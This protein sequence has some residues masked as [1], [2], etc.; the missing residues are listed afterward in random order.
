M[1]EARLDFFRGL[2]MFIIF[3]AHLPL[4]PWNDWIPARFGP[5]DATEMFVFCSGFASAIAFGGTFRRHGFAIG[6]LRIAASLLAGLLV[7]SRPV[8]H[9]GRVGRAGHAG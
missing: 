1:R 7:A 5:S 4:N 6:T 9:R 2:A 3:I 8:P